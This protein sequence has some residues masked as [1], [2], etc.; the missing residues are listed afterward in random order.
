MPTIFSRIVKGE[1]PSYKIAESD[2]YYAFLDIN[3]LAMGHTLVIPKDETDYLFDMSDDELGGVIIF[4][5][6]VAAALKKTYPDRRV[7]M[8]VVGFD[9][10]HAHIHLVPMLGVQDLD[11][12]RARVKL[13]TEEFQ[14]IAQKI[15]EHIE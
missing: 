3:P 2:K 9:V 4:A 10:P 8:A 5:K 1:I 6:K 11:F 14:T 13:S 12:K 7:G 15:S